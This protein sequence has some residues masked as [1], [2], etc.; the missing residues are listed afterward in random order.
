MPVAHASQELPELP[1]NDRVQFIEAYT[2]LDKVKFFRVLI[3]GIFVGTMSKSCDGRWWIDSNCDGIRVSAS[4]FD[5]DRV[6]SSWWWSWR[7]S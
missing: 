1:P 3:D 7:N 6:K 2:I 5:L 4:G